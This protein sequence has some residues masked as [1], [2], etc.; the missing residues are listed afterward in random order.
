MVFA[1]QK[2]PEDRLFVSVVD[3]L[4]DVSKMLLDL[5]YHNRC[6]FFR[7]VFTFVCRTIHIRP[8]AR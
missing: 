5:V 3:A 6:N 2:G 1:N 4:H 8:E 7:H